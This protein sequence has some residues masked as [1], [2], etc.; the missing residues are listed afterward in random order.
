MPDILGTRL[1]VGSLVP[2]TNSSVEPEMASMAV[3]GVTHMAARIAIPNVQF[4]SDQDA[5]DLI[6]ATQPDLLPALSR[7]MACN[8]DRVIM[9]MAVPCFWGG[10]EGCERMAERLNEAAGVPVTL[11]PHAIARA[12]DAFGARRIAIVSPYMPV[13][14]GHVRDW[15]EGSGYEVAA[16]EGLRAAV[17]DE[18]INITPRQLEDR[19]AELDGEGVDALVHVGTSIAMARLVE[20]FEARF[21][22]PVVSVNVACWWAT[23]R[24]AGIADTVPNFGRLLAQH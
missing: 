13:A 8:P 1:K 9:A 12:L 20:G 3:P 18:V 11:P 7:L 23:L 4:N 10:V 17:E 6:E 24:E 22:K 15:F 16:I 19:F 14:D 2:S 21:G 5:V